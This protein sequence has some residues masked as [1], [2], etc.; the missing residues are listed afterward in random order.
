MKIR[1][2][3][4][5]YFLFA[6][7]FLAI[8]FLGNRI[9]LVIQLRIDQGENIVMAIFNG[10]VDFFPSFG[11]LGY[12]I[13]F[14]T[15]PILCSFIPVIGI[16]IGILWSVTNRKNYRIGEEHGSAR[17]GDIEKE[18]GLLRDSENE[19]M[20]MIFSKNIRITMDTRKTFLNDNVIVIGGSGSGKTRYFVKPN[21]LQ[22]ACNY[23][24]T[25]PKGS[26]IKEVG[27]AFEKNGYDI[28]I[29][30]LVDMSKSMRYNPFKYIYK[31]NDVLKFIN[32]LIENTTDQN[33]NSGGD[34]FF[35]K[36]EIAF[37]TALSFFVMA[38][39]KDD[40][41]NINTVMDLI[42]LAEASEEDE[43]A[44]SALDIMFKE[45]ADSNRVLRQYG[46]LNKNDYGY[47][48]E[49][50]YNLYK[51]AA[52]KTAKSILI[53]VGVRM[54]VFNIPEVAN[55][56]GDDDLD[57]RTIGE[58][59]KDENGH[60]I[61]T[62]LFCAISDSDSTFT[63][64]A[65]ILYQQLYDMLYMIADSNENGRLPIHTRF[66]LDEFANTGKQKDFEIKVAT[67]RSREISVAV[68]L[69]NLAQLKNLYKDSWET[70]FGNCDTTLFLGGKEPSTLEYI[71]KLIGN[72][73]IDYLSINETKGTNGSWSRSNQLINRPLLAPDEI[74]RLKT[75]ECLVHVRGYH[76]FRDQKYDLMSH[77]RID[78]TTDAHDK[79]QA[80]DNYFD[81][82]I[83]LNQHVN[84]NIRKEQPDICPD[85]SGWMNTDTQAAY[86]PS[87]FMEKLQDQDTGYAS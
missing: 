41:R 31:P 40:E 86:F 48:A 4:L 15:I 76:I 47:L 6:L 2:E 62:A 20:D 66:K 25:D 70:I 68:I 51:K 58:P 23:I 16:G 19:D 69:Q 30:N 11:T 18:A 59:K 35:V 38:C 49:R 78:D 8:L 74:G 33:K 42:D 55:L 50:Q 65:S 61:K 56:L 77:K 12:R 24:I 79:K 45:L 17:Y 57:L 87:S 29:L 36:A 72:T 85:E 43:N 80:K 67:M 26:L 60:M 32:N 64:I 75:D 39:G 84:F 73:T 52:G 83:Y 1:N 27:N 7:V 9:G 44:E 54:S 13:S 22:M 46:L 37:L 5:A 71:S 21:I 81:P 53:S 63:F 34:D 28:K 82:V 14:Q 10:L 3:K